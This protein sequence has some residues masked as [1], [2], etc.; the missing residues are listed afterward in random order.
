MKNACGKCSECRRQT[1]KYCENV[2]ML[3]LTVH[4]AAAE[5]VVAD[6]AWV[7]HLPQS[8]SFET[9]APLMCAGCTV[10][11]ALKTANLNSGDTVAIIGVGALGHLGVQ[12]AKCMGLR[13]VCVDSRQAPL[14]LAKSLKYKPDHVIDATKGV[15][16]ALAELKGHD[17]DAVIMCTDSV[18]AHEYGLQLV[19][20][21][22]TYVVV[23]QP[24]EP[25]PVHYRNLIGKNLTLKGSLLSDPTLAQEM[26]NLVAEKGIEVKTRAY[27]LEDVQKLID[28]YGES[29]HAGKLVL[30]V[31]STE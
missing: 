13:V 22:G 3:G 17:V 2:E 23:G 11:C 9:A 5:Y 19:R 10:Y 27:P 1:P 28:D 21:H 7:I 4:G 8:L 16:H 24:F 14:E 15:E 31:S 12:F 29:E 30:R 18:P 20:K 6:A 25:I 26:V